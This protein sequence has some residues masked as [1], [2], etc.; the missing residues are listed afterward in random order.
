MRKILAFVHIPKNA[1]SYVIFLLRA[2]YGTNHC[3]AIAR[4]NG[5]YTK[6]DLKQDLRLYP[7][8]RS[9]SS[10]EVKPY[11]DYGEMEEKIIWATLLRNPYERFPS[12]YRWWCRMNRQ[13]PGFRNW[14]T[15]RGERF[16]NFQTR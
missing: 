14:C 6:A 1:G 8:L 16:G 13:E 2:Y 9:F 11:I 12:Q 4:S 15:E 10:H 5:T 3:R 7:G